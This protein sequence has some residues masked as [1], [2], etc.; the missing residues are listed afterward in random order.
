MLNHNQDRSFM[1]LSVEHYAYTCAIHH[2]FKCMVPAACALFCYK[3][4][5]D[6][7]ISDDLFL[8]YQPYCAYK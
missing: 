3:N 1:F 5:I 4:T 6:P 2:L 7:P 8:R